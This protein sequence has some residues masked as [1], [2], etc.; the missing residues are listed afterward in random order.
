MAFQLQIWFDFVIYRDFRV[1]VIIKDVN[2]PAIG[3]GCNDFLILRHVPRFVDLSLMID[4][5]INLNAILLVLGN[6]RSADTVGIIIARIFFVIACVFGRFKRD[7]NLL[8]LIKNDLA[9]YL[10]MQSANS[11]VHRLKCGFQ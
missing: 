5:D 4:L 3:L 9:I 11:F 8:K 2:I 1:L 10:L 6:A 7:F